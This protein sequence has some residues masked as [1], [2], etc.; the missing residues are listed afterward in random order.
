MPIASKLIYFQRRPWP[1]PPDPDSEPPDPRRRP[2]RDRRRRSSLS[3]HHKPGQELVPGN[4]RDAAKP[5][6]LTG[7]ITEHV[8]GIASSARLNCSVSDHGR[9]PDAVQQARERLLQ[10]LNSVDLSGR[11]QKTWPS[12][13][14]WTG[15][16]RPADDLR[17]STSTDSILGSL[18]NCFQPGDSVP[19]CKVQERAANS[20][21]NADKSMPITLFPQPIPG[22]QHEACR[23]ASEET[24]HK[25][26]SAECSICLERCDD[27]EGLIQLR[28][29]HV[30]HSSCLKRWLRSHGD[31]P[32]CRASV[33]L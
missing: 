1:A 2:C 10:R 23:E 16:T 29:K 25:E 12:G 7:T 20:V 26:P 28:C 17:V 14:S 5:L 32:Y 8:G 18:T 31:C 21:G 24:E 22:L 30:F 6:G 19:S 15:L 11:R 13:S 4:Q 27:A 9:L 33:L 3:S